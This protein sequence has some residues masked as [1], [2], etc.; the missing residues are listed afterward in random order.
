MRVR[1]GSLEV[2]LT[3]VNV[4]SNAEIVVSKH[5]NNNNNNN[6]TRTH[7][8]AFVIHQLSGYKVCRT[9]CQQSDFGQRSH[10][11]NDVSSG[12]SKNLHVLEARPL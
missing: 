1:V 9:K 12:V 2:T 6:N 11:E 10:G 7:V 5:N 3:C 4:G 8:V